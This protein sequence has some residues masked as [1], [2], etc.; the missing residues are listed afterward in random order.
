[1][2]EVKD[3][4]FKYN[5]NSPTI[6]DKF[7]FQASAGEIIIIKGV[8]GSGK[9]TL[10]NLLCG[11]IPKMINGNVSGSIKING[12]DINDLSLPQISPLASLL[13]QEPE[14]QLFFPL[15]E[16]ELAFGPENLKVIPQEIATR[17][18]STLKL[19]GIEHLR[20]RETANLSFGEKK[21][22]TLASLI[23]LDP[24]IF[25]LDEP[26]AGISTKSIQELK[27]VIR[28]LT[29]QGKIIFLAEHQADI[30]AIPHR[31]I[32]LG[33]QEQL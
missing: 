5:S 6:L 12:V 25:L 3:L 23:T 7:N 31:T 27:G 18:D 14:I 10:L 21:L 15:V 28:S 11:V 24:K 17:I 20:D 33:D 30:I 8:S 9:T 32:Y 13:M 16:Q 29:D 26:T 19:L 1:M 4:T 22:V 2:I